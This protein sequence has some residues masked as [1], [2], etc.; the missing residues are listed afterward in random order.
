MSLL[1]LKYSRPTLLLILLLTG[2]VG[3]MAL[4]GCESDSP[5]ELPPPPQRLIQDI[6]NSDWIEEV[7]L[8]GQAVDSLVHYQG[9][10]ELVWLLQR[11]ALSHTDSIQWWRCR[12]SGQ[13]SD[14]SDHCEKYRTNV[15][16]E[17]PGDTLTLGL[18]ATHE[19]SD[20]AAYRY[21]ARRVAKNVEGG[22]ADRTVVV[23]RR[24][25]QGRVEVVRDSAHGEA[26]TQSQ[27]TSPRARVLL[28][29]TL[30]D[31]SIRR[32]EPAQLVGEDSDHKELIDEI[33]N[34]PAVIWGL[35]LGHRVTLTLCEGSEP[36]SREDA[37]STG[38]IIERTQGLA[39]AVSTQAEPAQNDSITEWTVSVGIAPGDSK[40]IRIPT[41]SVPEL[42]GNIQSLNEFLICS[43]LP[44]DTELELPH[45]GENDVPNC[46]A[47]GTLD[48]SNTLIATTVP[49][50]TGVIKG[51]VRFS[52]GPGRGQGLG[53]ARE[54]FACF[55]WT[56]PTELRLGLTG[57]LEE[58]L[59]SVVWERCPS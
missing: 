27:D 49:Y 26:E 17:E 19:S 10:V 6:F 21:K 16:N 54:V 35:K 55:S 38:G 58:P 57:N 41:D 2:A 8:D 22:W 51:R 50:S 37:Q 34:G 30:P 36:C 4:V 31:D 46:G 5:S 13:S 15:L 12:T 56:A 1:G 9:G 53:A 25:P 11:D 7:R 52:V 59:Q 48:D 24:H 28:E 45:D 23:E 42:N 47:V 20:L 40:R 18:V 14:E 33:P 43:A 3:S 39:Y 44:G 29:V 32:L